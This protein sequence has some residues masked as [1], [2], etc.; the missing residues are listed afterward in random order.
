[1]RPGNGGRIGR[2]AGRRDRAA[3]AGRA[4]RLLPDGALVRPDPGRTVPRRRRRAPDAAQRPAARHPRHR[5]RLRLAH[6]RVTGRH[7]AV[8]TY[9]LVDALALPGPRHPGRRRSPRTRSTLTMSVETYDYSFPAQT[10]WH[11]WFSRNL[12]ERR[13]R[14]ARLHARLAGGARRRPPPHR[15][16]HRRR[17]PA[18]GTTA[19]ACRDGVDVTAHLAGA[20]GAEGRQPRPSGSSSTTSR[21]EAVCV[22]PQSGPPERSEHP[23]PR[24]VTPIDPLGDRRRPGRWRA[25]GA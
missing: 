19:S 12:G 25:P 8:F 15:P 2:A 9:D 23:T 11:P 1:M 5:P 18:P 17:S 21:T 7:E 4:V 3:A 14:T 6:R 22:E 20:A 16:A 13:G 24:L 10:G